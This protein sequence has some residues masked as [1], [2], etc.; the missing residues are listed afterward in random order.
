MR[1]TDEMVF[2]AR[3]ELHT[4][5]HDC[6]NANRVRKALEAAERAR[7]LSSVVATELR[8]L[9]AEHVAEAKHHHRR[10]MQGRKKGRIRDPLNQAADWYMRR[11]HTQLA[12]Q[13]KHILNLLE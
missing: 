11:S 10:Y 3:R 13:A 9:V 1:I 6:P 2:V 5:E 4:T 12:R 7:P 8:R